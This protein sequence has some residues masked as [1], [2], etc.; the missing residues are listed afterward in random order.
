MM[1]LATLLVG[2]LATGTASTVTPIQKV[3]ELMND[4]IDELTATIEKAAA[5][6]RRLTDRIEELEEDNGRWEADK[7]AATA[8]REKENVDF[9]ATQ[10]DYAQS[11][12][13]LEQA[14]SVLKKQ[15]Y[16]R[17]QAELLQQAFVQ[18]KSKRIVPEAA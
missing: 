10:T 18:L 6:I 2:T 7:K 4:K 17:P 12:S 14:I 15:A 11:L 5:L 9:T 1:L 16:D 3:L 8:V 13:A